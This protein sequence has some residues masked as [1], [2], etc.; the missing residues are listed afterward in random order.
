MV[1]KI[2]D[3]IKEI[4]DRGVLGNTYSQLKN[5]LAGKNRDEVV[6]IISQLNNIELVDCFVSNYEDMIRCYIE[7]RRKTNQDVS[8]RIYDVLIIQKNE[9]MI[10]KYFDYIS[11][12]YLK[13]NLVCFIRSDKKKLRYI[14]ESDSND[15]KLI[16]A[17]SIRKDEYKVI[18]FDFIKINPDKVEVIKSISDE[19][20]RA[21]MLMK[22]PAIFRVQLYET[23]TDQEILMELYN[24]NKDNNTKF[25]LL[26]LIHNDE[27]KKKEL[28]IYTIYEQVKIIS[29][30]DLEENLYEIIMNSKYDNYCDSFIGKI[31]NYEFLVKYFNK[32]KDISFK[33]KIIN[34]VNSEEVKRR[35]I[36]LL[37][38]IEYKNILL[39]NIDQD[40]EMILKGVSEPKVVYNIDPDITIGVELEACCSNKQI[41]LSLKNILVDWEI[42]LDNSV[43]GGVEI[44]SP[45][46]RFDNKSI[47]ELKYVCDFLEKNRFYIDETCGGHIH[48]G[49]DYFKD[50]DEFKIFIKLYE[51]VEDIVYL[52]S[53]RCFSEFRSGLNHYAAKLSPI[54]RSISKVEVNWDKINDLKEYL[55]VIKKN[56]SSRCFGLNLFNAYDDKNTVEFRMPNGEI[57]FREIVLNIKLFAKLFEVSK[58][59]N[60]IMKKMN[61]SL[62]EYETLKLYQELINENKGNDEKVKVLLN[63][64]F[65]VEEQKVY[66]NRYIYNLAE[67]KKLIKR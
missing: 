53:N 61:V 46:L 40:K 51:S 17:K 23:I 47:K 57:E 26:C 52:I 19:K 36:N 24:K 22:L 33:L 50:I 44:T 8:S 11:F 9:D 34:S 55:T 39:G 20:I 56:C 2:E 37:D 58:R 42:K 66:L 13:Q 25:K 29:S 4:N 5:Y 14:M 32:S 63:L 18:A 27:L 3:I 16:M 67:N 60:N 62:E 41:Y 21:D 30:F 48:L 6:K 1:R 10:L 15:N 49:F 7:I 65:S 12:S 38:D 28:N 54:L 59:I 45:I 64:L 43:L 35:L 31:I